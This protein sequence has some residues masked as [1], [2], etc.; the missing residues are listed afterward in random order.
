MYLDAIFHDDA[1]YYDVTSHTA[2]IDGQ[3]MCS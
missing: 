2:A 3:D 1:T